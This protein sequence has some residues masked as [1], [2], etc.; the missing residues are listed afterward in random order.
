MALF[1]RL[2]VPLQAEGG[3]RERMWSRPE[4]ENYLCDQGVLLAWANAEGTTQGEGPLFSPMW[5]QM[6]TKSIAEIEAALV[7]LGQ[8]SPWSPDAKVTDDFLKPL[9]ESF[10]KRVNLPNELQK[11]NYHVL[12]HHVSPHRL[13]P[14]VSAVLDDLYAVF[15]S[16]SLPSQ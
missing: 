9:F 2:T 10:F 6:M 11:T 8:A 7:T 13:D 16:A 5:V 3:L 12:A 14:E 15:K 4:I 1:D